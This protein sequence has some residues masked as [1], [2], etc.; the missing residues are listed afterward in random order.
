MNRALTLAGILFA[1]CLLAA[2]ERKAGTIVVEPVT[3]KAAPGGAPIEGELGTLF[4][5]ENRADPKSRVI[6]VGFA[7]FR[8]TKPSDAPPLFILPGGPGNS[9]LM[10]L[11]GAASGI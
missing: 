3:L 1:P 7:R 6:G 11:S 4:V 8:A 10:N 5:P 9:F 2:G